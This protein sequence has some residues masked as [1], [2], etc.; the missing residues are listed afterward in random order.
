M[1][2]IATVGYA[3]KC[4]PCKPATS[5]TRCIREAEVI[6]SGRS[7]GDCQDRNLV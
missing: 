3:R 6:V 1:E 4:V 7:F 5:I 2:D